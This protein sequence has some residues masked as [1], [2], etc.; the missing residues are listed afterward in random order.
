MKASILCAAALAMAC[1]AAPSIGFQVNLPSAWNGKALQFG[2]GGCNGRVP[3]TVGVAPHGIASAPTPL[4]QGYVTPAS[5]SGHQAP[6]ANDA[7]FALNEEALVNGDGQH[8]ESAP[9]T[10]MARPAGS[11]R[12]WWRGSPPRRCRTVTRWTGSSTAWSDT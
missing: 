5:D 1:P 8:T 11:R 6:D 2:G 7:S 4:A 3:N 10:R 9:S 12:P